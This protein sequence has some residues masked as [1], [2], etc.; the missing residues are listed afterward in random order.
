MER[1]GVYTGSARTSK[2]SRNTES[3]MARNKYEKNESRD[4]TE[5][6][7]ENTGGGAG[8]F[9]QRGKSCE[10]EF[11]WLLN[12]FVCV[13]CRKGWQLLWSRPYWRTV[14]V[15]TVLT[16]CYGPDRTDELLWAQTVLTNCYGSRPYWR[17][18]LINRVLKRNKRGRRDGIGTDVRS[19]RCWLSKTKKLKLSLSCN[20]ITCKG[21]NLQGT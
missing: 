1:A 4:S 15:Q 10:S 20:N 3:T 2:I 16:N 9:E 14:M 18:V 7:H 11:R 5:I 6:Y 12:T 21:K 13:V 8:H 17:T 19:G